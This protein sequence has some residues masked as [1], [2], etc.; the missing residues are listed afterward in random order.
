MIAYFNKCEW[1]VLVET[2]KAVLRAQSCSLVVAGIIRGADRFITNRMPFSTTD[3]KENEI[4]NRFS[5]SLN[6]FDQILDFQLVKK[7]QN[8]RPHLERL[9]GWKSPYFCPE[10]NHI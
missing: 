9:S 4:E 10:W 7:R 6:F 5:V 8:G 2:S 1:M 3:S